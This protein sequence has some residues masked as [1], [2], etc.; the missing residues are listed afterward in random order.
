MYNLPR[1][2]LLSANWRDEICII[3]ERG[4]SLAKLA[5]NL[6]K[7]PLLHLTLNKTVISKKSN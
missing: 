1:F 2:K 7:T 6:S 3:L 5:E 4:R